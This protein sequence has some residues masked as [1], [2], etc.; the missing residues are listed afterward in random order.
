M[1][2]FLVLFLCAAEIYSRLGEI[3]SRFA[4]RKFPIKATTGIGSQVIGLSSRFHSAAV[5]ITGNSKKF[6]VRWEKPGTP[7]TTEDWLPF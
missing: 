7:V 3:Y 1:V 6:P 2:S 5:T 4:G